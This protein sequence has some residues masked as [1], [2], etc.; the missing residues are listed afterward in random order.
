MKPLPLQ[1]LYPIVI[2]LALIG[3]AISQRAGDVQQA[4]AKLAALKASPHWEPWEA[5][6]HAWCTSELDLQNPMVGFTYPIH[7]PPGDRELVMETVRRLVRTGVKKQPW[8]EEWL[9][10]FKILNTRCRNS[11]TEIYLSLNGKDR[12]RVDELLNNPQHATEA[13]YR[14]AIL[15]VNYAEMATAEAALEWYPPAQE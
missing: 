12:E 14:Q 9:H 1:K 8:T 3:V 6:G 2:I 13:D 15:R 11:W 4:D 7:H 10:R 5:K